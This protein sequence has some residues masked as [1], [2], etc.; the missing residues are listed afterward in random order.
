M[1]GDVSHLIEQTRLRRKIAAATS[2][3]IPTFKAR[4]WSDIAQVLLDVCQH[5][6]AG[7]EATDRGLVSGWI[8]SYL[9]EHPPIDELDVAA[10]ARVPYVRDGQ[11][12]VFLDAFL[13][14]LRLAKGERQTAKSVAPLIRAVGLEPEVQKFTVDGVTTTR[15]VWK[16]SGSLMV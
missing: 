7:D 12:Y 11:T 14:W 9:G 2:R 5:V 15:N 8:S 16:V 1:L 6:D 13:E 4:K 3:I 10:E